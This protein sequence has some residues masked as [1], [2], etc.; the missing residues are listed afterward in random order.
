MPVTP[1]FMIT[2]LIRPLTEYHGIRVEESSR[3]MRP[4]PL[5]VS[6]PS[7]SS[8]HFTFSPQLPEATTSAA[9]ARKPSP[10]SSRQMQS[11]AAKIF[12]FIGNPPIVF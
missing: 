7:L 11:T 1:S 10:P 6:V 9:S 8:D 5:M 3:W 4:L 2:F 12:R